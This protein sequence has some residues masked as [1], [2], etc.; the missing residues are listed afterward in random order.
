MWCTAEAN[1]F[2]LSHLFG[3]ITLNLFRQI[4]KKY[5]KN[6]QIFRNFCMNTFLLELDAEL[7]K[8]ICNVS[9]VIFKTSLVQEIFSLD[10]CKTNRK[11]SL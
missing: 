11:I 3:Q 2:L 7:I 8:V 4:M 6:G 9:F 10:Q 5:S 1:H